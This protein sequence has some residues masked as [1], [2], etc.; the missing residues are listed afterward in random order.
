MV[1]KLH[2]LVDII[3]IVFFCVCRVSL[4]PSLLLYLFSLS[5]IW[6]TLI[7]KWGDGFVLPGNSFF[8]SSQYP[9]WPSTTF[10]PFPPTQSPVLFW[11][12]TFSFIFFYIFLIFFIFSLFFRIWP[13]KVLTPEKMINTTDSTFLPF[14]RE[15]TFLWLWLLLL[16]YF[17]L[18]HKKAPIFCEDCRPE[19]AEAF[20]NP[21]KDV[22]V[23]HATE[24]RMRTILIMLT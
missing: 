18:P 15:T 19:L 6:D 1:N 2:C 16:Q 7:K 14:V 10:Y 21:S 20:H 3:L 5:S 4:P 9:P 13:K 12:F 24:P 11:H 22:A 17:F 8:A 23:N